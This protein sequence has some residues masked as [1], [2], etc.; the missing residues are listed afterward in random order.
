MLQYSEEAKK[1]LPL[2]YSRYN[3]ID[4]FVEDE[5][6]ESFYTEL[7]KK[8]TNNKLKV[9]RIFGLGG[10]ENLLKDLQNKINSSS[11]SK[12]FYIADGDFDIIL[13]RAFPNTDRLHVL[14]AYCI[15]NFLLEEDAICSVVQEDKPNKTFE[16]WKSKL[17][18]PIW[19]RESIELLSPLF[20]F[21]LLTQ[22]LNLEIK[23]V[24]TDLSIFIDNSSK[25]L[26]DKEKIN[27]WIKDKY[28]AQSNLN[29]EYLDK[30]L[31]SCML[32]L[33]ADWVARKNNICAKKYLLP[34]LRIYVTKKGG[35][36]IDYDSFRFRLAKN[37]YFNSLEPLRT[38]IF[39]VFAHV[40]T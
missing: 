14:N 4:I 27:L 40:S 26:L 28:S 24:G 39:Q 9:S 19:L 1:A 16:Q 29:A 6:D 15:E 12:Q 23:N 31:T 11:L 7:I 21:F 22:K 20:A 34:L 36:S 32:D 25:F 2:F 30:L 5:R 8:I 37:C 3:D 10:K 17:E 13:N 18:F 35:K 38:Q 33:G